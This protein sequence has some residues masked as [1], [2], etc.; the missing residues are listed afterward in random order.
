MQDSAFKF[1]EIHEDPANQFLH[2]FP[3]VLH[4]GSPML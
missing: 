1:L 4:I 2:F 3:E